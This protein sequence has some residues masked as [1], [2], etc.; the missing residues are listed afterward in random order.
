MYVAMDTVDHISCYLP[1]VHQPCKSGSLVESGGYVDAS[2]VVQS[3][4]EEQLHTLIKR[5]GNEDLKETIFQFLQSSPGLVDKFFDFTAVCGFSFVLDWLL[6]GG[7]EFIK[8]IEE[9]WC[10]LEN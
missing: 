8:G 6:M 5:T 1:D 7:L 4:P 10:G 2:T 3:S 9:K